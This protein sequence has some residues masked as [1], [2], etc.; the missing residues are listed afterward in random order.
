MLSYQNILRAEFVQRNS[1]NPR[2]SMR[3]FARDLELSQSFLSQVMSQK[4]KLSDEKA[5]VIASKLKLKGIQKRLFINLVRLELST[6]PKTRHLLSEE[7]NQI[8]ANNPKFKILSHEAFKIIADWYYFAIVELSTLR[9]FKNEPQW[10][11]RKLGISAHQAEI[12]VERLV[13]SSLLAEKNG[14]LCKTDNN[15]IFENISSRAIREHHHQTL[16]LAH[17][18]IE[19]QDMKAREFYTATLTIDPQKLEKAKTRIQEFT[20]QF[21][22]EF[23]QTSPK[24]VYKLAIQFFR[25]DK[26]TL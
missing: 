12:A 23:Q 22:N 21:M 26:E 8:T 17:K 20:T 15:Y 9:G 14:H 2:Y 13:R 10:I 7:I 18:A 1:K 11:A 6:D 24:A 3:G 19:N 4:R 5:V 25:L 16:D